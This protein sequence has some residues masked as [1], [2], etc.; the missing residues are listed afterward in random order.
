MA[1]RLDASKLTI[2]L[3]GSPQTIPAISNVSTKDHSDHILTV[4]WTAKNGWSS[5]RITPYTNLSLPPTAN[6]LH[7]ATACFEGMKLYRGF[8]GKLRLFR[9]L[10]NCQRLLDSATRISLPAF[11]P[12]ELQKLIS[13]L[14]RVD[15][16]RWLPRNTSK[17]SCLYIRP[18]MIGID[19]DLGFHVPQEA[20]LYVIL[21]Y[22]PTSTTIK[23]LRL[24]ANTEQWVR[25]WPGGSGNTKLA[26]NYGPALIAHG[27]A[28]RK[29][30]DQVLWLF[31]AEGRVTEAGSTNFFV[32][33]KGKSGGTEMVTPS[34]DS[35]LIL[36]GITRRS[37]LE[38]ARKRFFETKEWELNG[39]ML[40][41]KSLDVVERDFTVHDIVEAAEEG[42]LL[43]AFAVGTA[44][45]VN[46][47]S[48]IDALGRTIHVDIDAVP[49]AA[50]LHGWL[51][52]I[53]Y[54]LEPSDWTQ[55][56]EE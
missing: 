54:G 15:G 56:V 40:L 35:G 25:A 39:S 7:Y 53:M 20:L 46:S 10:E 2:S 11:E 31:G 6:A 23:P 13:E 36:P 18:T 21:T 27:E 49:Y 52:N 12:E 44:A 28:K 17:G 3:T 14:C 48:Q 55:V 50:L 8:D 26:A 38:L 22:W 41:A 47:V 42:R 24:S 30:F 45:F 33:W 19:A 32:L 43:G 51:S 4:S 29:G 34:L 5:P 9:P 37:V 16:P 1:S